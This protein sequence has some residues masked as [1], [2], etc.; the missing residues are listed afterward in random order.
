MPA[1]PPTAATVA[2]ITY[3]RPDLVRTCLTHLAAQTRPPD[4]VLVVDSSPDR[5]TEAV[6]A[7]FPGTAYL[8]NEAGAGTMATSRAIA[9]AATRTDVLAFVDDDAFAD[10]DWLEQLLR[11]YADPSVAAVGGRQRR[12]Q[13]GEETPTGEPI[14]RLLPDGRLT[15]GFTAVLDD[16]LEVD[17]LLGANM[18]VRVS[19]VRAL[20]GIHDH[21][22]G[23][24]LREESDMFLRLRRAGHRVVYTP[25]A[26][27]THVA[28]PY[29][30]GRRFDLRYQYYGQRNHV[31]LLSRT[32]GGPL[33]R[34]YLA[35]ALRAEV[36]GGLGAG[37]RRLAGGVGGTGGVDGGDAGTGDAGTGRA[38]LRAR[39][40]GAAGAFVRAAVAAAGLVG[41]VLAAAR[42]RW[43]DGA[44]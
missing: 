4:A 33:T 16:D 40:R 42:L 37:V 18:S 44:P 21:Y 13:T 41:G 11:P 5:R 27:V 28:A 39:G 43:T 23:T 22:P 35:S 20:G 14:G 1:A 25:S 2:V 19:A 29:A 34:R 30:R 9:L 15:G 36:A 6:V 32:Y 31:V 8:R 17:H 24:C 12:G 26:V 10:A 38:G 3:C 7:D